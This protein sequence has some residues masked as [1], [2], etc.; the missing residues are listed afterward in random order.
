MVGLRSGKTIIQ[1]IRG[2]RQIIAGVSGRLELLVALVPALPS[3]QAAGNPF[4]LMAVSALTRFKFNWGNPE[5][6]FLFSK[7]L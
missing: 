7:A 5:R 1:Q 2:H 4:A 6:P 3:P